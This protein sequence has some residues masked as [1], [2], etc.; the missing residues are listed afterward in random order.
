MISFT[1]R[2]R[3]FHAAAFLA[4]FA[5]PFLSACADVRD[6]VGLTRESP[7]EFQVRVRA[8]LSMPREYGLKAPRPGLPRPQEARVRDRARQIVLDSTGGVKKKRA[9]PHIKGASKAEIA[10]VQK[11]GADGVDPNI[12]SLVEKESSDIAASQKTIA[13]AILFWKK[14]PPPGKVVDSRKEVRRLQENTALGRR[15]DA[16]EVPVITRKRKGLFSSK[17]FNDLF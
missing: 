16:G 10:L 4:L 3:P 12:R 13:D 9:A 6:A 2:N 1:V 7:D 5:L 11:L 17:W 8:P 14:P 15:A